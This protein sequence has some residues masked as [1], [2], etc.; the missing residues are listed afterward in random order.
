MAVLLLLVN[1]VLVL[2]VL[3]DCSICIYDDFCWRHL[4]SAKAIVPY[5]V[6]ESSAPG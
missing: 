6:V 5:C 3:N 2:T 1:V 4:T